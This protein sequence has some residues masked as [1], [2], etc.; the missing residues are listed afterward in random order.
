M[1]LSAVLDE[2][3]LRAV[4]HA[5]GVEAP[6]PRN[7]ALRSAAELEA[8]VA[9]LTDWCHEHRVALSGSAFTTGLTGRQGAIPTRTYL[10]GDLVVEIGE[11]IATFSYARA[12]EH[13]RRTRQAV[14]AY[15]RACTGLVDE[16]EPELMEC[17]DETIEAEIA[18]AH[19]AGG[20]ETLLELIEEYHAGTRVRLHPTA[21]TLDHDDQGHH[22][23]VSAPWTTADGL[24]QALQRLEH[25]ASRFDATL[26]S[27]GTVALIPVLPD[28]FFIDLSGIAPHQFDQDLETVKSLAYEPP[29]PD[30]LLFRVTRDRMAVGI[31]HDAGRVWLLLEPK[32]NRVVK[33][34]G[35]PYSLSSEDIARIRRA[36]APP[37]AVAAEIVAHQGEGS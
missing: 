24:R 30:K 15:L 17:R 7:I 34:S 11:G 31:R 29:H 18:Q 8:L 4:V 20:Y 5:E 28:E 16:L 23:S 26:E 3:A 1:E 19:G 12:M 25:W 6:V 2:S 27:A 36:A 10:S 9:Q 33:S 13:H 37:S 14:A 32:R 22:W 21:V 35:E